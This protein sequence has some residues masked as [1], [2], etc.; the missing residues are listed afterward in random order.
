MNYIITPFDFLSLAQTCKMMAAILTPLPSAFCHIS[1]DP[2]LLDGLWNYLSQY[3]ALGSNVK[4]LEI[5]TADAV[6]QPSVPIINVYHPRSTGS[7]VATTL[8]RFLSIITKMPELESFR[9]KRA[10]SPQ[11][12]HYDKAAE[13]FNVDLWTPLS[14]SPML[15]L[16]S[17]HD[18]FCVKDPLD[19]LRPSGN[20]RM[21]PL[22]FQRSN[23]TFEGYRSCVSPS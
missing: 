20:V 4:H 1:G 9:W 8:D 5:N 10:V 11:V 19:D 22:L 13:W 6:K 12:M 2:R 23:L 3:P 16:L 14:I 18:V 15:K 21:P 17:V 7:G